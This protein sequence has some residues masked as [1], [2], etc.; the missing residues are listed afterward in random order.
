MGGRSRVG[1]HPP[2]LLPNLPDPQAGARVRPRWGGRGREEAAPAPP[3]HN[4]AQSPVRVPSMPRGCLGPEEGVRGE[5]GILKI[6]RT[7]ASPHSPGKFLLGETE[8]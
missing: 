6:C 8:T 4:L 5:L 7:R 1:S 3:P 2:S